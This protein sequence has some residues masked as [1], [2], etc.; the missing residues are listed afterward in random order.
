[1]LLSN[2]LT[3]AERMCGQVFAEPKT[4]EHLM[5]LGIL[6]RL[7]T[8]LILCNTNLGYSPAKQLDPALQLRAID[9]TNQYHWTEVGFICGVS[10][11]SC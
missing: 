1:M 9:P 2:S 6:D 3:A 5:K 10:D 11:N 4:A 8:L 7:N